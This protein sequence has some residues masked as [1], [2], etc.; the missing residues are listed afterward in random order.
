MFNPI[1]IDFI[2]SS[3]TI[4]SQYTN[5]TLISPFNPNFISNF[6][7]MSQFNL[8][9][10]ENNSENEELIRRNINLP[11]QYTFE[12]IKNEIF[13][14]FNQNEV[15]K[16]FIKDDNI[17]NLEKKMSDEIYG[18]PKK[19]N[20]G[21][22]LPKEEKKKSGRKRKE[23]TSDSYHN[24]YS[25]DNIIKK[26]KTKILDCLLNFINKLLYN[27]LDNNTI[28]SCLRKINKS[29]NEENGKVDLIK[30]INYEI[31]INIMKKDKN[32]KFLEMTI[33][34]LLSKELSGKFK[35]IDKDSNKTIIT[36]LLNQNNEILNFIFNLKFGEWLDIFLYKKDI[37]E[38]KIM[39]E[40]QIKIIM[41]SFQRVDDLLISICQENDIKYVSRFVCYIYNFERWFLIKIGREKKINNIL[42]YTSKESLK[43]K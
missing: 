10:T 29:E 4:N 37:S 17:I 40:E 11:E 7:E 1:N 16:Y 13:P 25:P 18:Q 8:L 34:E 19:R 28:K 36:E 32:I 23:D 15:E 22:K 21:I 12:K 9:T 35:N 33:N 5:N 20:R 31:F 43:E 42:F 39:N 24:K 3:Y 14:K 27:I 26:I 30:S 41:N 38:F 2:D 6:E